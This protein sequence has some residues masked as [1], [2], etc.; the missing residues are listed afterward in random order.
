MSFTFKINED[1]LKGVEKN[2]RVAFDK[3]LSNA[4]MLN[5]IGKTLTDDVREQTRKG[6][7][8]PSGLKDLKLLKESWIKRKTRLDK[9]NQTDAAYEE[10][11]SNLTFTGQL[12]NAFKHKIIG[13][14]TVELSFGDSIHKPYKSPTG[15]AVGKEIKNE[16]LADYVALGGRP[17]VG[18]RPAMRLRVNRIVR[19]Y[20]KRALIVA[21]LLKEID[22]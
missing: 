14:G 22:N 11:G 6:K 1:S 2:I 18:V 4:N 12:L 17:F 3:A 15:K 16:D 13:K 20:I 9:Y 19:G 10:G 8:I 21:R 5:E 7:S